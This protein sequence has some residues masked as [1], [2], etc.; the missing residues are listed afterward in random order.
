LILGAGGASRSIC[1]SL[2]NKAKK[3]VILNRTLNK[4]ETIIRDLVNVPNKNT[5]IRAGKLIDSVLKKELRETE[6]LINATSVG[7]H[8][9]EKETPVPPDF[10][11]S[12]LIV[13]DIIYNPLETRLLREA[14]KVGAI[15]VDGLEMLVHQGA[16]SFEI[17]TKKKAPF[18]VM[19]EAARK[20]MRRK[21]YDSHR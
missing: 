6:I 1:F 11:S 9:N 12:N 4:G 2:I 13:F 20:K 15:T 5:K 8:P 21:N 16:A 18:N 14:K 17:F 19:M 7:M 10:L 3:I